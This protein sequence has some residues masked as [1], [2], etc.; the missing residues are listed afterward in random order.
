LSKQS[1]IETLADKIKIDAETKVTRDD[2]LL[3]DA[4]KAEEKKDP[5]TVED[6]K[7]N[8]EIDEIKD[9]AGKKAV[10]NK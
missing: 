2:L 10:D 1:V 7:T 8:E 4:K 3:K 6:K 9:S 5:K